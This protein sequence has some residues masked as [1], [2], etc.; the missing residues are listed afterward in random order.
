MRERVLTDLVRIISPIPQV[1]EQGDQAVQSVT[2]HLLV[3][4]FSSLV[5]GGTLLLNFDLSFFFLLR[6]LCLM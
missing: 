4:S 3:I 6:T 5:T 2:A 1:T